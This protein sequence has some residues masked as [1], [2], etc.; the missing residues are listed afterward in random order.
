[1]SVVMDSAVSVV[2]GQPVNVVDGEG[3]C[4]PAEHTEQGMAPKVT[5]VWPSHPAPT[6]GD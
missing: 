6:P 4:F 2:T 5:Q 1:M 3:C